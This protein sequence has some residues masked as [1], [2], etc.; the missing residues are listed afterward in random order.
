LEKIDEESYLNYVV[1]KAD[2][3]FND[4]PYFIESIEKELTENLQTLIYKVGLGEITSQNIANYFT[5]LQPTWAKLFS[6]FQNNKEKIIATIKAKKGPSAGGIVKPLGCGSACTN[7]GFESGTGFW[8]YATG[9]ACT[10]ADPCSPI[11]GFDPTQH[12][13][14][15]ASNVDPVVGAAIPVVS[16]GGGNNAMMLG[17]YNV[18]GYG[19]SRASI[20]FDVTGA[21]NSFT[22]KYAV[23]LQD[24]GVTHTDPERPYFRVKVRDASGNV[25]PCGDFEVIAK[26]PMTGFVAYGNN[27]YY[28]PWTTV[29]VPLTAYIGQCI[30]IEFTSS[31]CAQGGHY[32]YAYVDADCSPLEISAIT[33]KCGAPD[34]LIAPAG[35]ASYLWTN[36]F[37]GGT[38]GIVGP[39]NGQSIL[40]NATG[41]YQ[42]VMTSVSGSNC[43]TTITLPYVYTPSPEPQAEFDIN[44]NPVSGYYPYV[45]FTN[46]SSSDVIYWD[47]TFGDGTN[48]PDYLTPSPSHMYPTE[49]DQKYIV[50]LIV[51]NV[52]GCWDTVKHTVEVGPEFTFFIPNVFSPNGDGVNDFFFGQGIGIVK[53]DIWIFDRW[54]DMIFHG[55]KLND[56]WDG[57]ANEGKGVAQQDVYV[58][59]VNLTDVFGEKHKYI[60]TVTLVK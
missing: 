8:D 50:T 56:I 6:E 33:G 57:R 10:S 30:T 18:S 4:V 54:G 22:Y 20:S 59:K 58:W 12:Q 11:I 35:A 2:G 42:V 60:G 34:T 24:P 14:V 1:L 31:D 7:P 17:N 45:E 26:P 40:V 51:K 9:S 36:T 25:V 48:H 49:L 15:V 16:P 27:I 53:Y 13:L 38:T 19:A 39:A 32:G 55:D 46:Q 29:S 23:V 47:W 41:N 44:P 3:N 5:S 37:S 43:T 28:K 52:Y 21:D